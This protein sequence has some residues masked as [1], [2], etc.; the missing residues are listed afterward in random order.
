[1]NINQE[2]SELIEKSKIAQQSIEH[3][4]QNQTDALITAIAWSVVKQENAQKLARLA[5]DEGGFGNFDDKVT[6]IRNRVIG[7]INDCIGVKTVGVIEEDQDRGLTKIA[8]PVGVVAALI[9]T[10][11]PDATPPLKTILAL[12]GRNSIIIAAHP[13]TQETSLLAVQLMR[14]A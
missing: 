6:K 5:V 13:Y 2:I 12:K 1:M 14:D 11:G 3:F 7:T 10:T 8:K 4:D 9:P